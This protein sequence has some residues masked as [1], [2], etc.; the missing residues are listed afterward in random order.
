[1][2]EIAHLAIKYLII[3]IDIIG[4][5]VAVWGTGRAVKSFV[6]KEF[7]EEKSNMR[8][9]ILQHLRYDFGNA[10]VLSLEFFLAGDIIRTVVSPSQEEIAKLGALVIIRTIL[11]YFLTKEIQPSSKKF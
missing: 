7:I 1:M 9:E 8:R 6:Y 2:T 11:S 4:I 5:F 3:T 10:L